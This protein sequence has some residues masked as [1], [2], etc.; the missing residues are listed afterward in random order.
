MKKRRILILAALTLAAALVWAGCSSGAP[1][2]LKNDS[3]G[4]PAAAPQTAEE[5]Y[6]GDGS[7][8][9][10]LD[11]GNAA[12][13]G[14]K[15][16]YTMDMSLEAKDAAAA[17]KDIA[18]TAARLGGY[19]SDSQYSSDSRNASCFIRV[20]IAPE[21]LDEFTA[22][23]GTLGKVLEQNLSSQ[24]ITSQYNDMQTHLANAQA[25]EAQY[26]EI[27]K[28]ARTIDETMKVRAK[29]DEIQ[30]EIEQ[31]K[32]QMRLWDNQVDFSTVTV[33]I[34]QPPAPA[35]VVEKE[36]SQ[37][38]R[39]WGFAAVWQKISRGFSDGFN[40][41]LNAVSWILMVLSYI[42]VPLAV[43]AAAIAVILVVLR[44]ARKRKK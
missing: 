25:E 17:I 36:P 22:H 33:R 41:T 3:M 10:T 35:V 15:V 29:L 23:V 6:A 4:A 31:L 5:G 19:V 28:T 43:V 16:I 12:A 2:G 32:G 27:M 42:V 20:R 40:W 44:L 26:L 9:P 34:Q 13:S 7:A 39:F 30:T 18:S 24:D 14:K 21:K 8:L 11:T 37:G 38:V 1:A